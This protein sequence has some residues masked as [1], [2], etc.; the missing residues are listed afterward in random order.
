MND[1]LSSLSV[2]AYLTLLVIFF[3]SQSIHSLKGVIG[4]SSPMYLYLNHIPTTPSPF[5]HFSFFGPVFDDW[6]CCKVN[7]KD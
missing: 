4:S 1:L 5:L 2:V 6:I 3:P 7:E